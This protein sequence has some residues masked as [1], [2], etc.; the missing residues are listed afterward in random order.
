MQI[1]NTFEEIRA[2]IAE[3]AGRIAAGEAPEPE[4]LEFAGRMAWIYRGQLAGEARLAAPNS[5]PEQERAAVDFAVER[6][7]DWISAKKAYDEYCR[8]AA[9]PLS[10]VKFWRVIGRHLALE[11]RSFGNRITRERH[12][13]IARPEPKRMRQLNSFTIKTPN[14]N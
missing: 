4:V 2:M 5:L 8:I 9:A 6:F 7:A 1:E 12:V 13:R 3:L 14:Y 11:R 10:K